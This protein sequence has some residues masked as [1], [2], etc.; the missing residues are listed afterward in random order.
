[1]TVINFAVTLR[2]IEYYSQFS[3]CR[4]LLCVVV[5]GVDALHRAFL[6]YFSF[7]TS[8]LRTVVPCVVVVLL[9]DDCKYGESGVERCCGECVWCDC[10]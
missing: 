4:S 8:P 6:E 5:V 9:V 10:V 3:N 7:L 2:I 1:M